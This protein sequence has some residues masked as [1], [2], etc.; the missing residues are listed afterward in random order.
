MALERHE[1]S[2]LLQYYVAGNGPLGIAVSS[3]PANDEVVLSK[4]LLRTEPSAFYRDSEL[5]DLTQT[6]IPSGKADLSHHMF[7]ASFPSYAW[8]GTHV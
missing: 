3:N 4:S 2:H 7:V 5:L 6:S 1:L 8:A